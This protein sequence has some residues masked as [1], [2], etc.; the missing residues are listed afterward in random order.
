MRDA[1]FSYGGEPALQD[2]TAT[3]SPGDAVALIGPNGSGK[4]TLLKALL[5]LVQVTAGTIEVLGRSPRAARGLIGFMPQTEELDPEFPVTLRQVVMMGRYRGLGPAR[6]PG[7]A[8][9]RAVDEAIA[10]VGLTDRGHARFGELSGGQQ[11]RGIL[12]RAI[13]S[14]PRLVLL[15]EPFNGLDKTN[16]EALLA[17][18]ADLRAEGVT[19]VTSTHD[20]Q[21]ASEVCS[22]AMLLNRSMIAFGPTATT[23]TLPEIEATFHGLGVEIDEHTLTTPEHDHGAHG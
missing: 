7:R 6:W 19:I 22:H 16:R 23:L 3:I 2:V 1:A 17:L 11:Q 9:R 15:D 13:V 10:R 20:L 5:G 21:L 18:V 12:A 14:S 8:D 4:S